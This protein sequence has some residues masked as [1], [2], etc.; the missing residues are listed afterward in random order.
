[1][2]I[3]D[4]SIGPGHPCY[5]IAE[6][7][8]NHNGS[9]EIAKRLLQ[10]AADAN[11]DAVKLQKRLLP[12]AVPSAMR[13]TPKVLQ[14]G[15]TTTYLAY[16]EGL[17]FSIE[18]YKELYDLAHSLGL[19]FGASVWDTVSPHALTD[20]FVVD[21]LKLPSATIADEP[22]VHHTATRGVP[23]FWSTGMYEMGQIGR[24]AEWLD[25]Y[26]FDNW[27]VFHCNSSYP[28][29][30]EELNLRVIAEWSDYTMFRGHPIGYSG[31]EVGLATT[32]A[33]VALGANMVERHITLDR[34]SWGSDHA[35]S[36]EPQ[37]FARLVSDIRAVESAMGDGKKVV[38]PSEESKKNSL[39]VKTY[40]T[41]PS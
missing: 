18:Q 22:I 8:I 12:R 34:S 41:T 30:P 20:S 16:K 19:D 23:F 3:G 38:W 36:V 24:T 35:S 10:A 13:D 15:T 33:A 7:G 11:V 40:L 27:G 21:F 29:K 1:M 9:L 28:A 14:D 26:G 31:H 39:V 32:V 37:G 2:K 17:E 6:V 25:E 4:R 5:I